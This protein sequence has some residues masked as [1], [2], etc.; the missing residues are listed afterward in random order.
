VE[1]GATMKERMYGWRASKFFVGED[2]GCSLADLAKKQ[3]DKMAQ[4][5]A[6]EKARKMGPSTR[7]EFM[8]ALVNR[9]GTIVAA[10]RQLLDDDGNGRISFGE[11]CSALR[12]MPYQANFTRLWK[13]LD[14]DGSGL[15]SLDELDEE[16]AVA[17]KSFREHLLSKFDGLNAAWHQAFDTQKTKRIGKKHFLECC[18]AIGYGAD[19]PDQAKDVYKV[20]IPMKGTKH[21][22]IEDFETLLIGLPTRER[23]VVW[24]I[25]QEDQPKEV[26]KSEKRIEGIGATTLEAFKKHLIE[27]YGTMVCAWRTSL[28]DD[29]NGRLSFGELCE[30]CRKESFEGN[31]KKLW[32]ELDDDDSGL[33]SLD[34]LDPESEQ[35]I[36]QFR[37]FLLNKFGNLEAAWNKGFDTK[38]IHRVNK[39][40]FVER[41]AE[42]EY[43]TEGSNKTLFKMLLP[44]KGKA[45]LVVDDFETLLIGLKTSEK[46]SAWNGIKT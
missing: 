30:A 45:F 41:C 18:E 19:N 3:L 10:W 17:L 36:R 22:V 11:L 20:L 29:G 13:E 42:I 25:K 9:Y 5:E 4:V 14:D 23:D 34:E 35:A 21:L 26:V 28:D 44:K 31:I 2:G 32:K 8:E 16:A 27:R 12:K 39:A 15:V 1:A 7:K 43:G 24:G 38:T 6:A 33:I 37:E 40:D 46:Q